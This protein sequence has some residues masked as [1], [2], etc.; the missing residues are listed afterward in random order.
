MSSADDIIAQEF[1]VKAMLDYQVVIAKNLFDTYIKGEIEYWSSKAAQDATSVATALANKQQLE[2]MAANYASKLTI[3]V[4][5]MMGAKSP[6]WQRKLARGEK[7]TN[8]TMP[9]WNW[10]VTSQEVAEETH[11]IARKIKN[12]EVK[13]EYTK[14][15]WEEE[16][17]YGDRLELRGGTEDFGLLA[18]P[19]E[20][21]EAL[22]EIDYTRPDYSGSM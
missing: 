19:P 17:G 11:E 2:S 3:D 18:S 6:P 14:E 22:G 1:Q 21:S 8:S 16:Y 4:A 20:V 9:T 15:M 13:V 10:E 12:G 5:K 7:N